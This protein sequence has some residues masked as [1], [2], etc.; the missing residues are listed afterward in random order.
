MEVAEVRD[1]VSSSGDVGRMIPFC[2]VDACYTSL[3]QQG[4]VVRVLATY[5]G[6][7]GPV[8]RRPARYNAIIIQ[9]T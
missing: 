1:A 9:I 6:D 4:Q 8:L 3:K 5:E 2:G 7:I